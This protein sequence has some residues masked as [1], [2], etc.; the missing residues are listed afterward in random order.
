MK[1][2]IYVCI[3]IYQKIMEILRNIVDVKPADN[4]KD[5]LK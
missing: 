3:Y 5:Y 4:E 2:N 1:K